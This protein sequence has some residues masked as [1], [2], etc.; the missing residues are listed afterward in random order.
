MLITPGFKYE[1]IDQSRNPKLPVIEQ[2]QPLFLMA[3][4]ADK[5]PEEMRVVSQE[6]FFKLYGE[7]KNYYVKHGQPLL[8][9][10]ATVDNGGII[11]LKRVVADDATLA[12]LTI[13][14]KVTEVKTQ[15]TNSNGES[16]YTDATTGQETTVA[17]GNTPI[18]ITSCSI[19][20]EQVTVP[21]VKDLN[22]IMTTIEN[23]HETETS[24]ALFTM[25]D[26]GRG[27]SAKKFRINPDYNKSK[28][29]PYMIYNLDVIENSRVI[30]TLP[31]C[32]D[33]DIIEANV[34]RSLKNVLQL[35][36][37]QLVA[38]LYEDQVLAFYNKVA[39]LSGNTPEYCRENDLLFA[40]ERKAVAMKNV[41]IDLTEEEG[42]LSYV[43]GIGLAEGSNGAFG[44]KP[45]GTNAYTEQLVNFFNGTFDTTIYDL[46]NYKIDLIVDANY[47]A[48]VKREI[49]KLV[50]FREDLFYFRDLGIGLR[51]MEDILAADQDS[52]KNKFCATYL[53]SY[54]VMDPYT[55]KQIPVTVGYS[56]SKMLVNH[57]KNGRTR[58]VAGE[59]YNMIL[60]D[61][62]K[63]TINFIPKI[64][65]Q[66]NQKDMLTEARINYASYFEDKLVLETQ[67]TSQEEP[68]QLSHICNVLGIQEIIKAVRTRCPKI[69]YSFID[70]EDLE[71]YKDDVA[72]VLRKYTSN[73]K[74]LKLIYLKDDAMVANNVFYAAIEVR[75]RN[76]VQTEYF[77]VYALN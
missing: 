10:A 59:A 64:I 72:L 70:G 33:P 40:K 25:I 13:V 2:T 60:T 7:D 11:L 48:E 36:S 66:Y 18:M 8:Q 1:I 3:V 54:D 30:E 69:R 16:L 74:D 58:P 53:L 5:G 61:A 31:F 15:K 42:D 73:F 27:L 39:T 43:Y 22:S 63:G 17:E 49:E 20:Y 23:D 50:T 26:N 37:N 21:N 75:F 9:A 12:N 14:A 28:H 32:L 68:T 46:D 47:P 34:N 44:E 76:F 24:F 4:S 52:I 45:F 71:T 35:Y 62:I 51:T 57:F 29:K 6:N 38:H 41:T 55:R 65:P 77:K 19:K 67:F 56:L